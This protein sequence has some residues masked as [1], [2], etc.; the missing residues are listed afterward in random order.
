MDEQNL[1]SII[2]NIK[3]IIPNS[4]LQN[5]QSRQ[6]S[7]SQ[8]SNSDTDIKISEEMLSNLINNL[9]NTTN[10]NSTTPNTDANSTIDL[11]TVLKLKSI[12]EKLNQK[13][14]PRSNLLYSLKPY[15]RESRKKKIDQYAN[16]LKI[17]NFTE[18]F[19]NNK[20]DSN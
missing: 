12:I 1:N 15:L 20:G 3:K 4:D 7:N 14:D 19:K 11:Q 18:F 9:G 17:T 2:N 6:N 13:D 8:N 5:S 16:L 10:N